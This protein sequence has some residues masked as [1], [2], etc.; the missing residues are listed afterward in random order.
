[1][2][3]ETSNRSAESF[4]ARAVAARG[5]L[6]DPEAI[7]GEIIVGID[8]SEQSYGAL[9]WAVAEAKRRHV[10]IRLVTAY[11]LP[12]FTGTGF[13]SGYSV[14]DEQALADGVA[15]ILDEAYERVK[16]EG[17][18]L[19]ATVETGDA[20]SL[21]VRLSEHAELMVVGSRSARGFVGRLLGTVSTSLPAHSK[22]PVVVVPHAW[23]KRHAQDAGTL[24]PSLGVAVGS[25]GSHQARIAIVKAAEEAQRMGVGLKLVN[26]LAPY[27]GALT[28]VPAAVDFEAMHRE[29]DE[30]Q[31]RAIQWIR[32]HFP[33]LEITAERIDG[34]PVQVLL[35]AGESADLVVV[36]TRGRGGLRG[37]LLG[38]IS[39]GVLHSSQNPVMIVP[40]VDD[41]RTEDA[42]EAGVAWG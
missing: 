25:D 30:L 1:M 14:I 13:D 39:Q 36:G 22:C 5:K 28:W 21:L 16:E 15:Q 8:G 40:D 3:D 4:G 37:M 38:S 41:P 35:E 7:E 10:P 33:D 11:S 29:I 31:N 34:S 24:T 9:S 32:G 42:P 17:I 18:E 23:A 19:R 20:S 26:A 2:T 27:T 12:V 6:P